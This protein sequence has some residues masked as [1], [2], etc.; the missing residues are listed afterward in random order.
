MKRN[1]FEVVHSAAIGLH[2]AGT[3]DKATMREFNESRLV[4]PPVPPREIKRIREAAHVREPV[5]ARYLN[6]HESTVQKREAGGKRP[7]G[8][9][10][11]RSSC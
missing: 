7:S 4:A 3:I 11:W 1:V 8:Q 2:R 10:A 9:V 6:N 5:F